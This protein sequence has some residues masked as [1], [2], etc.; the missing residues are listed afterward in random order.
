MVEC[1]H[2]VFAGTGVGSP[3]LV[4]SVPQRPHA[5]AAP[6]GQVRC[7]EAGMSKGAWRAG[8]CLSDART[9]FLASRLR[10]ARRARLETCF[11]ERMRPLDG[12][13]YRGEMR[14]GATHGVRG[15]VL[16]SGQGPKAVLQMPRGRVRSGAG[17]CVA[18]LGEQIDGAND[19]QQEQRRDD[20][21]AAIGA[22][23]V[24][25]ALAG[26]RDATLSGAADWASAPL[27]GLII[28]TAAAT[29]RMDLRMAYSLN[30]Q[31]GEWRVTRCK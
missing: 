13:A 21:A 19:R 28:E 20:E 24:R 25:S 27:L 2:Y 29:A 31:R 1:P 23:I 9:P 26:M 6:F 7:A 3:G 12:G 18:A 17:G 30:R 16:A 5:D 8:R 10:P 22:D 15:A 11:R 14:G 4:T